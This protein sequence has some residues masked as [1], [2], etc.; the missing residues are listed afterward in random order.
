MREI[1]L[2]DNSIL[3]VPRDMPV[4][5]I[6]KI[7]LDP[8]AVKLGGHKDGE[9]FVFPLETP[10]EQIEIFFKPY[11]E[12]E[13]SDG[14]QGMQP[15]GPQQQ[16]GGY[17]KNALQSG[18]DFVLGAGDAVAGLPAGVANLLMPKGLQA[19]MPQH[20]HGGPYEIGKLAGD[21][22]SFI[23]GGGALKGALKAAEGIPAAGKAISKVLGGQT[24]LSALGRRAAGSGL[25]GAAL[26]PEGEDKGEHAAQMAAF[27]ALIDAAGGAASPFIPTESLAKVIDP[28]QVIKNLK[29]AK[30][31]KIH[32][33]EVLESPRLTRLYDNI[34]SHVPG[35]GVEATKA[36]IARN[37]KGEGDVLLKELNQGVPHADVDTQLA[38]ELKDSYHSHIGQKKALYK[39][40][41]DAA[42]KRGVVIET[43]KFL[44]A[45]K[46]YKKAI[47]SQPLLEYEPTMKDIFDRTT[48][49]E[50]VGKTG[51]HPSLS[52]AN[53]LAAHLKGKGGAYKSSKMMLDRERGGMFSELGSA[54]K[55]D[56]KDVVG[57]PENAE[58]K[59]L[60]EKAEKNYA[61]NFSPFLDQNILN[62][63]HGKLPEERLAHTFIKTAKDRDES[64]LVEKLAGRLGERGKKL[65]LGSYLGRAKGGIEEATNPQKLTDLWGKKLGR[66]QRKALVP[67]E[68]ERNALDNY[69]RR[70]S[71]SEKAL[72]GKA[73]P[74]TGH[75]RL[76]A[77]LIGGAEIGTIAGALLRG[78]LGMAATTAGTLGALSLGGRGAGR[79]LESEAF[80][81]K[82]ASTLLSQARKGRA[83][84]TTRH[85]IQDALKATLGAATN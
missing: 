50:E 22:G 52:E 72:K 51:H 12:D 13:S 40:A 47:T 71:M 26:A 19:Q 41:T 46:G 55:E 83:P 43:P 79:L 33:G 64:G 77:L 84:H 68:S 28:A 53:V 5:Q 20:S 39:N 16:Q 75:S 6:K 81:E 24:G 58:I 14:P 8:K 7:G 65:L 31:T 70:V 69:T 78:D 74:L 18:E 48:K 38:Q 11:G 49:Y 17:L 80:R 63:V 15:Q 1:I 35:T 85:M 54:L 82:L 42:K 67:E 10:D 3:V 23:G 25:Y 60:Y 34:L 37:L 45:A 73:N 66:N 62:A 21:I 56:I 57:R 76:D 44:K 29:A 32:L 27:S 61:K 2:D 30:G 4:E 59:D 9:D 36:E